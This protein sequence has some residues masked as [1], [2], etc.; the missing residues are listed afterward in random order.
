MTDEAAGS[1]PA[2]TGTGPS[3]DAPA[4]SA[5]PSAP[6]PADPFSP[7][8]ADP[9]P[10]DP[11]PADPPPA[12]SPPPAAPPPW[13][14][15]ADG[16]TFSRE[17]LVR[18]PTGRYIAGVCAAIG[19]A[20]NTDPVLWRVLLVVLGFFGGVGVLLYLIGW[21][22]IPAEGD[23]GSPIESLL[24][25]GRSRMAPLTVVLL[26]AATA[27]T[28]AFIVQDGFRATLLGA[29]V[30]LGAAL[31]IRRNSGGSTPTAAGA[32]PGAAFASATAPGTP[33]APMASPPGSDAPPTSPGHQ[34]SA[35]APMPPHAGG[36]VP[37]H[38]AGPV[39]PQSAGPVPPH[40]AATL[41]DPP[42]YLPPTR[43][44]P[45]PPTPPGYLPPLNPPGG[46]REP[47][48]PPPGGYRPPFAPHG[49]WA[50]GAGQPPYEAAP[51]PRPAK[52]PKPPR[53]RSKLGRIT[54]FA[55]VMVMGVLALADLSGA[56][57]PVPGYFAAALA[58]I[59][60]GLLIG[61]WFGRARGLIALALI[62]TVG[63]LISSG[64]QQVGGHIGSTVYRP[65]N[66]AA[67]A[68]RYDFTVGDATLDL[69]GV[70]FA[71]QTQETTVEMKL[72]QLRVLLPE[73]VDTTASVHLD[74]G[75]ALVFG[76]E[77]DGDNL[78]EQQVV[79]LGKD[80]A[81]GGTLKLNIRMNAGNVEVTR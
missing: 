10:A 73:K 34:V 21:L 14:G 38:A 22:V 12:G 13:F 3:Q 35:A 32:D 45:M 24:G 76:R 39:P 31:L 48:A 16:P 27:V 15:A 19:R 26:G 7:P 33:A 57:V 53:E 18:P 77:W 65:A 78:P 9:P 72:G 69:R 46:Y 44:A 67:L 80:G 55:V 5:A 81:G 17:R 62:T 23:T 30:L 54:F 6:P 20:T 63:L 75:R 49:P 4:P 61:T 36:P 40:A 50:G 25:R 58:T 56:S 28:F 11:P 52:P 2:P 8:P 51:Q 59:G 70:D 47:L 79:D 71:G 74:T 42:G 43:P 29:A 41:P 37:P 64:A 1:R 68:D 66:L 60:L